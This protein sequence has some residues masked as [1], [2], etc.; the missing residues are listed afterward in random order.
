MFIFFLIYSILILGDKVSI[1]LIIKSYHNEIID[2]KTGTVSF[3]WLSRS[4]SEQLIYVIQNM[5]KEGILRYF[6]IL[7]VNLFI[8][9]YFINIHTEFN[10]LKKYYFFY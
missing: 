9:I 6:Y 1:N 8:I 4:L 3:S 5:S 7:I 2:I 10:Y